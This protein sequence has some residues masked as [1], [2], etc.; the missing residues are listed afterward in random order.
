[1]CRNAV[2]RLGVSARHL[3]FVSHNH[4]SPKASEVSESWRPALAVFAAFALAILGT[5][6]MAA[7]AAHAGA[8]PHDPTGLEVGFFL[9]VL[10]ASIFQVLR[11][12]KPAPETKLNLES[13]SQ[14]DQPGNEIEALEEK[15]AAL[16]D[17]RRLFKASPIPMLIYDKESSGFLEVNSAAERQ[18][19]YSRADFLATSYTDFQRAGN[20]GGAG[21]A[22]SGSASTTPTDWDFVTLARKDGA[23]L[24]TEIHSKPI[25]FQG[26]PAILV[27]PVDCSKFLQAADSWSQERRLL[28]SLMDQLPVFIY[29]KDRESRFVYANKTVADSK[30]EAN[31]EDMIGKSDFDYYPSD[32]AIE[33]RATEDEIMSTGKGVSDLEVHEVDKDGRES[34]SLNA[35]VP[36]V[37][38]NGQVVGILG[39]NRDITERKA[40]EAAL[41][42]SQALFDSLFNSLPQGIY[43]KD[44]DGRITFGNASFCRSVG[45]T[46]DNILGKTAADIFPAAVTARHRADDEK[47]LA[48]EIV[49]TVET[50]T[51][52]SGKTRYLQLIKTPRYDSK[53]NIAGL[54][55]IFWDVTDR[56]QSEEALERSLAELQNIVNAVSEGDLTK[57]AIEGEHV[58]G[59]IADSVNK[60]LDNFGKTILRVSELGMAVSSSAVQILSAGEQIAAGSQ[61]Q[62]QEITDASSAVEEMAASMNQVS[63]NAENTVEAA[64]RTL[65]LAHRGESAAQDAFAAMARIDLAVQSTE[66]KMHVLAQHS[67]QISEIL[68]MIGNIASQTN[69]LSLNAAIQAAH[70]GDAGVGFS[71][72]AEEIRALAEKSAQSTK[73]INKIIKAMQ[74]ETKEV[75]MSMDGVMSEVKRGSQLAEVAEHSIQDISNMVTQSASLIEEISAAAQEQARVSNGVAGAMQTVSSIAIETT[76]GTQ[77]TSAILHGLVDKAEHLNATIMRFKVEARA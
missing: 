11:G 58:L 34:W 22:R 31:P 45:Q 36:W 71:V 26:K 46:L 3:P 61:R 41:R 17:Y 44:K 72:V 70:A 35:R 43:C 50:Q 66:R 1:M 14:K 27:T 12:R 21:T 57:R 13:P 62:S 67:S 16:E 15:I 7:P 5:V 6:A 40:A 47:A 60:M 65:D 9:V 19:G 75:L 18:F 76:T 74:T 10:G 54:Q 73:D 52:P 8:T 48:G 28:K 24:K 38:A 23:R 77:E 29:A 2:V 4:H 53:G 63:R 33:Y 32:L 30:G 25:T 42:E 20:D 49:E 56:K 68:A 39:V 55:C 69:L 59:Q 51:A 37:D 64:R